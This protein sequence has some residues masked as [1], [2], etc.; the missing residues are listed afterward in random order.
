MSQTTEWSEVVNTTTAEYLK[1]AAD[2]TIRDRVVF[3]MLNKR[4]RMQFGQSGTEIRWQVKFG[5]PDVESYQGGSMDYQ[6]TDKHRQLW[7]DW[8]GYTVTDM[9]HEK[10]RLQNRGNQALIDRYARIFPDMEQALTDQ[11][12]LEFYVNGT[13]YSDRFAGIETFCSAT[14]PQAADRIAAPN[15]SYGGLT[16][17]PGGVAGVWSANASTKPNA[18]MATDWPGG[19]GDPEYAFNSP[20]LVNWSSTGWNTGSTAWV[21]NCERVLRQTTLW[22]QNGQGKSGRTDVYLMP[23]SLYYDYLNRQSSKQ[24]IIVPAKELIELGFDGV[25]QEGVQLTTDWGCPENTVYGIN[26]DRLWLHCMY[27]NLFVNK[28]PEWDMRTQSYLFLIA[29]Y[30]NFR[31]ESPMFFS[32]LYSYA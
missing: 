31:F 1:G 10:E 22:T 30:G 29:T 3:A 2:T 23:Q 15:G 25:Q 17:V 12:G 7:L 16:C 5:M 11:F 27:D 21:D 4:K 24:S 19:Q 32:K 26:F 18:S 20:K 9:M 13:S 8:K 28:G 6:P 14:T